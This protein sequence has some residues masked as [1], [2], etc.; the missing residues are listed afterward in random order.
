M[1]GRKKVV[2]GALIGS[3]LSGIGCG[4]APWFFLFAFFRVSLAFFNAGLIAGF[5][6]TIELVGISKRN[7]AG[8]IGGVLFAV[9]FPVLALLAFLIS[10]WRILTVVCALHG[11]PLLLLWW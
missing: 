2:F 10:N 4:V 9:G 8:L 11:V 6:L 1:F 3:I 5:P 7:L